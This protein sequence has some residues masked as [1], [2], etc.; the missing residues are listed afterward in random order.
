VIA[1]LADVNIE[2][3]VA[4]V[5]S[6]MQSDYW[7]ELWDHLQMHS[8]RFADVGLSPSDSD[9]VVWQFCQQRQLYLLTNNRNDDGADSLAATI[10]ANNTEASLPV[11]TISDADRVFQS[12]DY[13]SRVV[14][15]LFDCLL[16]IDTLQGSGRLFLP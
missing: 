11:F 15:T 12:K 3:H 13:T 2:G 5:V 1:L 4:R 8:L 7:R 9:A 14:E 6:V 16:R 10:R